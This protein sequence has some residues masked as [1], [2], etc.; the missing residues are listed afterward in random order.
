MSCKK[1]SNNKNLEWLSD[2]RG[3]ETSEGEDVSRI[4][5]AWNREVFGPQCFLAKSASI[6][7]AW[8]SAHVDE[9][10][11]K[12]RNYLYKRMRVARR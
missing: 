8:G 9:P 6:R 11:H 2:K 1:H 5:L 3:S 7:S 10:S 12:T 4:A